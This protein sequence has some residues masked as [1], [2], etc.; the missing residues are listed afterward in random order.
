MTDQRLLRIAGPVAAIVLT[1]WAFAIGGGLPASPGSLLSSARSAADNVTIA[2]G[3]LRRAERDTRALIEIAENVRSQL[4]SSQRLLETQ[5]AIEEMS[6]GSLRRS[7]RLNE[8]IEAMHRE[9]VRLGERLGSM[10]DLATRTGG[11]AEASATA[12]QRLQGALDRLRKRFEELIDESREL[13]RK[14][15]GYEEFRDGPG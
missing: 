9:I 10:S 14:A 3:N 13:N 4:E 12:A 8:Q 5:L 11:Q 2:A 15:R 1:A 7:Q 6:R